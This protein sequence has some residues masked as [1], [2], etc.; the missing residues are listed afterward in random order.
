MKKEQ[1]YKYLKE[2]ILNG[3]WDTETAINVS[4]ITS[5][6]N[7]SRTPINKALRKLE[8][9]G[10]LNIIPQV[11]V[12]VKRPNEQEVYEKMLVSATIDS[13]MTSQATFHIS[14][15]KLDDLEDLL[16]QMEDESVSH[17]EY[18]R[19]NVVFHTTI[20]YASG[21]TYVIDIAQELW[22]YLNY[23]SSPDELFSGKSRKQSQS[24]HWII[25]FALRDGDS[26]TVKTV[27]ERHML[28]VAESSKKKLLQVVPDKT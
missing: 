17:E 18:A 12:F 2:Q 24:E 23:V 8:H 28:R 6:L 7:I 5:M 10:Y 25:Y 4:D 9:E 21:L 20:I 11:G 15:D 3:T 14:D 19:L 1:A 26:S 16:Y 22:D 27:M 13:L